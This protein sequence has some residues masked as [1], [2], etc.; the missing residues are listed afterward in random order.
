V[1]S[2]ALI[3]A[4]SYFFMNHSSKCA[5][6]YGLLPRLLHPCMLSVY[7]HQFLQPSL[8]S[9]SIDVLLRHVFVTLSLVFHI[10]CYAYKVVYVQATVGAVKDGRVKFLFC[11]NAT[12]SRCSCVTYST[13][14]VALYCFVWK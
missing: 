7:I 14:L 10:C 4:Y 12:D 11:S 2:V 3:A 9:L 8:Y 6:E 1:T 5:R 13:C